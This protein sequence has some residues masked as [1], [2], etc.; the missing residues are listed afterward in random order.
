MNAALDH[1]NDDEAGLDELPEH[2]PEFSRR[3]GLVMQSPYWMQIAGDSAVERQQ[4]RDAFVH[5]LMRASDY[6]SLPE[7]V[8]NEFDAAEADLRK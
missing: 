4:K 3:C 8:R 7:D 6:E 5:A 1:D 2:T